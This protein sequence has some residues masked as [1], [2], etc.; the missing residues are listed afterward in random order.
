MSM[1]FSHLKFFT[2]LQSM[3]TLMADPAGELTKAL[4]MELTHPGPLSKGLYGRCKRH[5]I[6]AVKGEIKAV[7]ISESE[8]DPAGDD[9]PSKTLAMVLERYL[10]AVEFLQDHQKSHHHQHSGNEECHRNN[11]HSDYE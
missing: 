4:D 8:D 11:P 3:L 7:H 5:A 1:I 6:Y 9:D 10:E 2:C